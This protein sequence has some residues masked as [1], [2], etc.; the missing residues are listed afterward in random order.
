MFDPARLDTLILDLGG[1]L[2]DVDY[3][4]SARAFKEHGVPQFEQQFS[5][6]RQTP[7]FDRFEKGEI[8]PKE[9][10]DEVRRL[11]NPDLKDKVID[12]CWNA[13]LGSIPPERMVLVE[14]LR[15]RYRVYLLSNT[16]RI[17]V[18]AFLDKVQR[19]NRIADFR[20]EFDGTY[21]SCDMGM[22]KPDEAIFRHVVKETFATA[23]GTLFID[24]S[25][26][27]VE[28]ARKAGLHA[29]HLDLAQEDLIGMVQRLGLLG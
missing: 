13:M 11:L 7:L 19:E 20:Q 24:D 9:F 6:A 10:R 23:D 5:K 2:I 16:N 14:D 17:H 8:G 25:M 4:R 1:E 21:F 15:M 3:D 28:G 12:A 26:Q 27:H 18:P 22:R 29:E